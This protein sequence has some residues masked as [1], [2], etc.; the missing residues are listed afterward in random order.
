MW[1]GADAQAAADAF[2]ALDADERA[3]LIAY[4]EAL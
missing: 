2:A 4:L 3:D 1:H